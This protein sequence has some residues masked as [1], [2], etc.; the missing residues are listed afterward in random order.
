MFGSLILCYIGLA[1]NFHNSL[2][3]NLNKLF[4]QL[5]ITAFFKHG[6]GMYVMEE[7][8]KNMLIL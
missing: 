4:G 7:A 6:I 3:N 1:Q 2:Q 5:N 8:C